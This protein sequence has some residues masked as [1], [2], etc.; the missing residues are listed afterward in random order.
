V[1]LLVFNPLVNSAWDTMLCA[2]F[3]SFIVRHLL[4]SANMNEWVEV[5]AAKAGWVSDGH[6]LGDL[7]Q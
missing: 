6:V 1:R 5:V 4:A 2:I 3:D 7:G